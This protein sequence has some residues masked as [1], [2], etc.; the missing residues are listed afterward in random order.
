MRLMSEMHLLLG[1]SNS[2]KSRLAE[3]L[4]LSLQKKRRA[5]YIIL[6]P[7]LLT[8]KKC[9]I[10]LLRIRRIETKNFKP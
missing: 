10:K 9:K 1:G 6:P 4:A 8:T 5:N 7:V 2:G 3:K